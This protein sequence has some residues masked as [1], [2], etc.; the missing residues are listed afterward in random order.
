MSN[1]NILT[2]TNKLFDLAANK[3]G[4]NN[5]ISEVLKSSYREVKVEIPVK[6][7]EDNFYMYTGYRVQHN[8]ARGPYYGGLNLEK[9]LN[10]D[11][12]GALASR[13]TWKSAI[14][15]IPFGGS[16]GGINLDAS[17]APVSLVDVTV[18]SYIHKLSSLMGPYKDII[19]QG[20]N[21]NDA[22]MACVMDE[23]SKKHGHSMAVATGKPETLGGTVG[24]GTAL[25]SSAYYLLDLFSKTAQMQLP[26][27][28]LGLSIDPLRAVGF[29][30]Y[31]NYLGCHLTAISDAHGGVFNPDGF[32]L[33]DLRAYIIENKRINDYPGGES[34]YAADITAADV[35]VLIVGLGVA[36]IDATNASQVKAKIVLELDNALILSESEDILYNNNV[37]VVPDILVLSGESIIDYFEWI[38]N[39]QQFKWSYDQ[40]ND[41]M[42]KYINE[43]FKM[44]TDITSEYQVSYKTACYMLGISRV[45]EATRLRGYV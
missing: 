2:E 37:V 10:V 11:I 12:I 38:Q 17:D 25:V 26:G 24:R 42:A 44:L 35:D 18:R 33:E 15:N 23:Y 30:D 9:D 4:L 5:D 3:L 34:I 32:D 8:G 19:T 43:S 7:S 40:I 28:S 27:M 13:M 6:D 29:I 41:E 22:V 20:V 39:I 14:M 21:S 16:F 1:R 45:A 36:S 31:L